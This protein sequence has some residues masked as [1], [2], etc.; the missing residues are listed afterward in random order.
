MVSTLKI[1][2]GKLFLQQWIFLAVGFLSLILILD[3]MSNSDALVD[4][5]NTAIANIFTYMYLRAPIV[6]VRIFPFTV[7]LAILISF[8]SLT[9]RLEL[10]AMSGVGMS[11]INLLTALVPIGLLVGGLHFIIDDQLSTR[12]TSALKTWG[13]GDY[14]PSGG[15]GAPQSTWIRFQDRTLKIGL[16]ARPSELHDI[17]VFLRDDRGI[18]VE[19]VQAKRAI[20]RNDS[21]HLQDEV[22]AVVPGADRSAAPAEVLEGLDPEL[23]RTL[24]ADPDELDFI[25]LTSVLSQAEATSKPAYI[26]E[27]EIHRRIAQPMFVIVV[28][29]LIIPLFQRF[30]RRE[31]TVAILFGGVGVSFVFFTFDNLMMALGEAGQLPAILAAWAGIALFSIIGAYMTISKQVL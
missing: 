23:I 17:K 8:M 6:F 4:L 16:I 21:W 22:R 5:P 10:V 30:D 1:Y 7:V 29:L 24:Q 28:F 20:F 14:A 19:M 9:R 13:I 26:Y 27:L 11:Q 3:V 12:A 2:L 18:V 15:S 25:T 31:G